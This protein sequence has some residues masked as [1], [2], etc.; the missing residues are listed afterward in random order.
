MKIKQL[1]TSVVRIENKD[2]ILKEFF[3]FTEFKDYYKQTNVTS[4]IK[5]LKGLG[6]N[7]K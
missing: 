7:T 3:T 4:K 2:Q 6:S 1:K 5:Y